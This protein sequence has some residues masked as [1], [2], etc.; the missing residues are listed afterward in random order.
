MERKCEILTSLIGS[1]VLAHYY[2]LLEH[3]I[4]WQK[5]AEFFDRLPVKGLI[6]AYH[7]LF[8]FSLFMFIGGLPLLDDLIF[9]P[10]ER[11]LRLSISTAVGNCLLTALVEDM[12]YYYLYDLTITPASWTSNVIGYVIIYG[13]CVPIWYPVIAVAI[14]FFYAIIFSEEL[15]ICLRKILNM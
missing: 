11:N 15:Y 4:D 10:S 1:I 6:S 3:W 8:M 14:L 2:A 7:Y 5:V 9:R 12:A 13:I